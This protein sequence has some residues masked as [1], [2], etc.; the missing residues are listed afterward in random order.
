MQCLRAKRADNR[1]EEARF[2]SKKRSSWR[3]RVQDFLFPEW[4][5]ASEARSGCRMSCASSRV[6][7][8]SVFA[9]H[10]LPPTGSLAGLNALHRP[11]AAR[12]GMGL[13]RSGCFSSRIDP[14]RRSRCFSS[15]I[16]HIF[17]DRVVVGRQARMLAPLEQFLASDKPRLVTARRGFA[18]V[19]DAHEVFPDRYHTV[20]AEWFY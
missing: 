5:R 17:I 7:V 16:H 13:L 19:P 18:I 14:V 2:S 12:T 4:N 11:P 20:L 8:G 1:V 9:G 10:G 6:P 3:A 15:R